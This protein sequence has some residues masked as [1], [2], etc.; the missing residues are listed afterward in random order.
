MPAD[1]IDPRPHRPYLAMGLRLLAAAC[2]SAMFIAGR[3]AS[4]RGVHIFETLFY[5][6]ALALPVVLGWIAMTSGLGSIRSRRIGAHT[7][8]MVIGITGMALNFLSYILLPPAEAVT[9]GFTMPIFATILSAT[10]LKEKTGIHRWGA[11]LVGFIGVLVTQRPEAGELFSLGVVVAIAAAFMTACVSLILRKLGR[12]EDPGT[13]VLWYTVL[14]LPPLGL[15]AILYG[16]AHDAVTWGLLALIGISGGVA[17]ICLTAAL[18][19]APVSVVLP[20]EY[21]SILWIALLGL[22]I[23]QGWPPAATWVGAALIIASGLYIA[24]RE[25]LHSRKPAS[26]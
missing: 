13:I 17:Q 24:W 1:P 26:A 7:T 3:I 22:L 23:G 10:I 5:R 21:S 15:G 2:V 11:V 19:W 16:G 14:S 12:L 6:Q 9:I 8:R 20:M 18:R 4:A 25:H